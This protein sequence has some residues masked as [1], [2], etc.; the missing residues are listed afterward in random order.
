MYRNN[1][2]TGT[3]PSGL[4]RTTVL[5]DRYVPGSNVDELLWGN[6][7]FYLHQEQERENTPEDKALLE[8]ALSR[9]I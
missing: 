4:L 3:Q 1:R 7:P 2:K 8:V 6:G 5:L 9:I